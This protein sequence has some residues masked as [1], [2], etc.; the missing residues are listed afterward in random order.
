MAPRI[1]RCARASRRPT[2]RCPPAPGDR[3]GEG[4]RAGPRDRGH[5]PA[6]LRRQPDGLAPACRATGRAAGLPRTA[7]HP[8]HRAGRDPRVVPRS[9]SP[10][11]SPT[12]SSGP[13]GC[14]RSE[15][16][17][18]PGFEARFVNV[19]IGS[20]RDTSRRGGHGAPGRCGRADPCRGRR[21]AR[22]RA[23]RARELV[24]R[25]VRPRH[26]R[27]RSSRASPRRSR[28]AASPTGRIGFCLDTAHAWGA[29]VD[30]STTRRR[31]TPSSPSSTRHIGLDRL[32][33]VHL[34]DSKSERGLA[35]D[36][37]EHLGAGPD[38]RAPGSARLLTHPDLAARAYY[39][40][41]PGMDE[42]YDAVNV[43]RA[44]DL[45]AGRPLATLPPEAMT[46][47][48]SRARTGRRRR[49]RTEPA[50]VRE[51][52]PADRRRGRARRPDRRG[53]RPAR[54]PRARRAHAPP[55][56]AT[57]GTWDADQGHDMLVLRALVRDGVVPLLGPPTSIGDVPPRRPLLLPAR[58]GRLADRR[59]LAARGHARDRAVRDRRGGRHVVARAVDR[60]ARS[61]GSWP[62]S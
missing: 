58:P 9:T 54:P 61:R 60:R 52:A 14:S 62:G 27:R 22:R 30:L 3:H 17:A 10:A 56:L 18:G 5:R 34:N 23:A 44:Y 59:R 28:R 43:A 47:R 16:R 53:S 48:G 32:V 31:S 37:H 40:E 4:R 36:R 2:P 1:V 25:R 49:A 51:R 38:R 39:L 46:M 41:T 29:G 55:G 12:S 20:H 19:H 7:R 13:S 33:M 15:L 6:D 57:A 50:T 11:R 8:R 42:G 26:E 21:H 35:L 45:A 24:R